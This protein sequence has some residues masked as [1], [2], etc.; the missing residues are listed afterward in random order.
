MAI[1]QGN[2][3]TFRRAQHWRTGAFENFEIVSD[4][5]HAPAALGFVPVPGTDAQESQSIPAFDTCGR[6]YWLRRES[7]ELVRHYDFGNEVAGQLIGAQ[8]ARALTFGVERVWVLKEHEVLRYAAPTLQLLGDIA[9]HPDNRIA[10][11]ASDGGDGL[12]ALEFAADAAALHRYDSFGRPCGRSL[13]LKD[14]DR[15]AQLAATRD[16]THLV[17]LTRG[18]RAGDK[19]VAAWRLIVVDTRMREPPHAYSF[20]AEAGHPLPTLIAIDAANRIHVV[21]QKKPLQVETVSL[22]GEPIGRRAIALPGVRAIAARDRIAMTGPFGMVWSSSDGAVDGVTQ[23]IISTFITPTLVSPDGLGNR[24]NSAD[25]DVVLAVGS[26]VEVTVAASRNAGEVEQINRIFADKT[27]SPAERFDRLE[28]RITWREK[29]TTVYLGQQGVSAPEKLRYL[30]D[31]L[32]ESS[33]WLRVQCLSLP[34]S[35]PP[36]VTALRVFYPERSYLDFLPALYREDLASAA[37]LRRFLSPVEALFDEID[38]EVEGLPGKIDPRTAPGEWHAFLLRWLGF[39]AV[40][41]LDATTRGALLAAAPHLLAGRGTLEA[42]QRVLDILT[43]DCALIEDNAAMPAGWVLP[44]AGEAGGPRLGIDTLALA[45]DPMS[46]RLGGPLQL[47]TAR[48]K[49]SCPDPASLLES[50][51][52]LI[53][54]MIG[55]DPDARDRLEPVIWAFLKLF[56]PAHCRVRLI[57]LSKEQWSRGIGLDAG[58]ILEDE[59]AGQPSSSK[60]A[61]RSNRS[62]LADDSGGRLGRTTDLGCWQL[63]STAHAPALLDHSAIVD[64]PQCLN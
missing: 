52:G 3:Y 51:N 32:P 11:I 7:G 42:L 35:E 61:K 17:V 31:D 16:G 15:D 27:L 19:S 25:L 34:G 59:D 13:P 30:L 53:T 29:R 41:T 44:G 4:G 5:L 1:V 37:Q 39:S 20:N 62:R 14:V 6:L 56:V 12:W 47:G 2:R 21:A 40:E 64:G 49:E 43:G 60:E 57:V 8:H 26:A 22:F 48:L 38:E 9:V 18:R 55:I 23:E 28:R 45:G 58:F 24:W 63:P 33:I 10:S 50:A 54:V 36:R 46:L